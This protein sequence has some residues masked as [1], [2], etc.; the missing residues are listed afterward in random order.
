MVLD[1]TTAT[2]VVSRFYQGTA[3][4][5]RTELI[6]TIIT[7]VS[8]QAQDFM[9]ASIQNEEF[10]EN[11]TPERGQRRFRL[12]HAPITEITAVTNGDE[13]LDSDDYTFDGGLLYLKRDVLFD[14]PLSLV[15]A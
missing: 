11:F 10:S 13:T 15:V 6:E 5:P 4:T 12:V 7:S 14:D 8:A 1:V 9:G 2:R 3:T